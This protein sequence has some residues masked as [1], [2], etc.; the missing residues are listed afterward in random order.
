VIS[1]IYLPPSVLAVGG[2]PMVFGM[3]VISAAPGDVESSGAS[4]STLFRAP[5]LLVLPGRLIPRPRRTGRAVAAG[6]RGAPR[7]SASQAWW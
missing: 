7:V 2:L 6:S 4:P 5:S 1:A 3:T